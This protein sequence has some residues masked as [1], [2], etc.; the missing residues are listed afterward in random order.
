MYKISD[1][2][3]ECE[4]WPYSRECFKLLRECGELVLIEAYA[5]AENYIAENADSLTGDTLDLLIAEAGGLSSAADKL[6]DR[7][8]SS[9]KIAAKLA[10]KRYGVGTQVFDL[11][12]MI[13]NANLT[14]WG[15]FAADFTEKR[16]DRIAAL[17]AEAL[18]LS[19]QT[20]KL[21]TVKL[22]LSAETANP[23]GIE[24]VRA[25]FDLNT[26]D[27]RRFN[28]ALKEHISDAEYKTLK[29]NERWLAPKLA[30]SQSK[31]VA[32]VGEMLSE[33]A[34]IVGAVRELRG[35]YRKPLDIVKETDSLSAK[36]A[37]MRFDS[38]IHFVN[39]DTLKRTHKALKAA[40]DKLN[41]DIRGFI[42]GARPGDSAAKKVGSDGSEASYGA[43]FTAL[44]SLITQL[45]QATKT[46]IK[47][48]KAVMDRTDNAIETQERVLSQ[49]REKIK[50]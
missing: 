21:G 49:V 25:V 34:R 28:D 31:A 7:L 40:N 38:T 26:A 35:G 13:G 46:A 14:F 30:I 17:N 23:K 37:G 19:E 36:I 42:A 50:K 24:L 11:L 20:A 44:T 12:R 1:Y 47:D 27:L 3:A 6:I 18:K 15:K 4:I 22:N 45:R 29:A 10:E 43:V 32:S 2:L 16:K 48:G 41:E 5:E 8:T 33:T 39:A 9:P